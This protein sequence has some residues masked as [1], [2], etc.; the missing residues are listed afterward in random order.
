MLSGTCT[1][2]AAFV[3]LALFALVAL[4]PKAVRRGGNYIALRDTISLLD[5]PCS[6][7]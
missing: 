7:V 5:Q 2:P 4:T 3:L 1:A 6:P